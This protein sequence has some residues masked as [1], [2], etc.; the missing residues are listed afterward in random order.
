M[1]VTGTQRSWPG[2]L[3]EDAVRLADALIAELNE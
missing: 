3:A 1:R 2:N